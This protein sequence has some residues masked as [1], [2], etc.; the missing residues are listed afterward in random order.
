M[1]RPIISIL[2]L[3][4]C[5]AALAIAACRPDAPRASSQPDTAMT[6]P[7]TGPAAAT[8]DSLAFTIHVPDSVRAGEPVPI[9]LRVTNRTS[10]PIDLHLLG[11]T[12]AFDI[13]VTREDGTPVWRRLEGQA[14]QSILQLRTLAPGETLELSDRWDQRG[15]GGAAV[16]PGLY[17]VH[18]ELPTDEPEPLRTPPASLRILPDAG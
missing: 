18:G 10:A 5:I 4:L 17:R 14:V 15:R 16:P 1:R 13:V 9:A 12:I 7:P 11:R 3:A 2:A 6:Q 8:S